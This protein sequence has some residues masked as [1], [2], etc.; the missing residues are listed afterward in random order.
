MLPILYLMACGGPPP[1][2]TP[3]VPQPPAPGALQCPEGTSMQTTTTSSGEERWCDRG[4]V[5]NGPY[6]KT[7]ADGSRAVKGVYEDNLPDGDWMEWH[8]NGQEKQKGKYNRGKE[9]GSW[10]WWYEN[11]NRAEEGDYISGRKNGTWT[12][13]YEDGKKKDEGLYQNGS[14]NGSWTYY[15]DDEENTVARTERWELGAMKESKDA[16]PP[17]PAPK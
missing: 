6:V 2:P 11:G 10:T 14:K 12:T 1:E 8:A 3:P 15:N 4:G 7:F 9:T 5:M 16:A 17:K 13:W